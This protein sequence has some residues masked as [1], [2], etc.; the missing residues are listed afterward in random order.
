M[1]KKL[2][3]DEIKRL[4]ELSDEHLF[5]G[6]YW[7]FM[8]ILGDLLTLAYLRKASPDPLGIAIA[9][10]YLAITGYK[11]IENL[12]KGAHDHYKAKGLEAIAGDIDAAKDFS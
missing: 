2:I 1:K 6:A 4:K 11:M 8:N 5:I 10:A 3:Q 12:V 7:G 9:S